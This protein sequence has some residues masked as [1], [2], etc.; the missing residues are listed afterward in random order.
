MQT[1]NSATS[2]L[3]L[4]GPPSEVLAVHGFR[5]SRQEITRLLEYLMADS[6]LCGGSQP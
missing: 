4:S 1:L 3:V 6:I 5:R 2:S